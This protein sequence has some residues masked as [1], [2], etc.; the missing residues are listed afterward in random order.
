MGDLS[1]GVAGGGAEFAEV[2]NNTNDA[3]RERS[4]KFSCCKESRLK[5]EAEEFNTRQRATT[6]AFN[7][8]QNGE[9]ENEEGTRE[10]DPS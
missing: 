3:E 9:K 8:T 10:G 7:N 5:M 1:S 2:K 4:S 6:R